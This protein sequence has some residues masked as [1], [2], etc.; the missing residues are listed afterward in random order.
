MRAF[1]ASHYG[2]PDDLVLRDVPQPEP[3]PTELLIAV[4]ATT[5]TRTD[6]ATLR[7]HPWFARPMT[8]L[9]R[10]RHPIFGIDFA[11]RVVASGHRTNRFEVGDRVF[12]LS[13][14]RFGAHA[15]YLCLPEDAAIARIPEGLAADEVVVCE[16]AW[17]ADGSVG[18][19]AEGTEVLVYG[20]SGAIGTAAVQLARERGAHVT[21]VVGPQHVALAR[22]L[23]AHRVIDYSAEVFTDIGCRFDLVFDAVGKTSYFACRHLLKPGGV[24]RA[25]DL[26]P[27][28]SNIGLGL[29]SELS[30]TGRVGVPFP[31]DAPGFV[32]R[33]ATL[34][35]TGRYRGV[36]DRIFPFAD[37][38]E[39]YRYVSS[40]Q[41][42]GIVVLSLA[43]NARARQVFSP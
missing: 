36:V 42:T 7:A 21:A 35:G 9:I 12:G 30:K 37:T 15:E 14:E 27:Y 33:L 31:R 25:T 39:A 8:G 26:G 4:E 13:P 40:G 17:Y 19:L 41:K 23:G 18:A 32:A 1:V 43:P 3:G 24:F 22:R 28:W 34:M 5:V 6:E 2:T 16:G 29:W 11:G 38:P 10:P 20:A